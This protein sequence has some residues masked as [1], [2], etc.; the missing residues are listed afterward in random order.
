[1]PKISMQK[2]DSLEP[3]FIH[4]ILHEYIQPRYRK[5]HDSI[6]RMNPRTCRKRINQ[7]WESRPFALFLHFLFV[8]LDLSFNPGHKQFHDSF[9]FIFCQLTSFWNM[10]PFIQTAPA[11]TG[12][13]MLGNEDGMS[14]HGR[15]FSIIRY[16]C[17][18]Q[19]GMDKISRMFLN[20]IHSLFFNIFSI[21]IRQMKL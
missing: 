4:A 5:I 21:P 10:I 3:N 15:L 13:G 17:G 9:L 7:Q 19:S 20:C 18:S 11:A 2:P 1:M 6:S 8:F 12:T 14:M 16:F